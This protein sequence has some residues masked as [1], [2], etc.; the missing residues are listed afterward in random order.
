VNSATRSKL[1]NG[2]IETVSKVIGYYPE[3]AVPP[4]IFSVNWNDSYV[5]GVRNQGG[6]GS[7]WAFGGMAEI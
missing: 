5:T 2:Q 3:G 4:S 1:Q 6:C 7:C